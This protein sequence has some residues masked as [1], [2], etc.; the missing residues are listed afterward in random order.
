MRHHGE[1]AGARQL[2]GQTGIQLQMGPLQPQRGGAQQVDRQRL[3]AR[4]EPLR[5]VGAHMR[6]VDNG[7]A[8]TMLCGV[9]K[10]GDRAGTIAAERDQGKIGQAHRGIGV[11]PDLP[12]E[13]AVLIL[14]PMLQLADERAF[15]QRRVERCGIA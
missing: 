8:C 9:F 11:N 3:R 12:M 7:R 5:T 1:R 14:Q 10:R 4:Y 13:A 15:G 6:I 2:A